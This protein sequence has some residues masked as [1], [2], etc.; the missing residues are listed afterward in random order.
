MGK[1]RND[2]HEKPELQDETELR[3]EKGLSRR[4]FFKKGA[5]AGVG[6]AAIAGVG[7]AAGQQ[8]AGEELDWD[9]EADVVVVGSG[10][11]GLPAAIRARDLGASVLV[12]EQNF[13]IGGSALHSGGRTSLGGGDALQQR[14]KEGADPEGMGLTQP[15]VPPE[16]LEDDPDLL[17]RDMTDWSVAN[18]GARFVYRYNERDLHR[19]WAD[20]TAA[21]RQFLMDNYVRFV[22]IDGTHPGGGV[23]RARAARTC[24][25]L[26]DT[27]DIRAGTIS[28]EDR[29]DP[30]EGRHT[31][32]NPMRTIPGNPGEGLGAP[33]W[34]WGG[35]ALARSLEF[36]AKE[37]GVRFMLNR[38]MDE[39]IREQQFSGRVLGVRTS[40]SPRHDPETGERLVSYGEFTGGEW[41]QGLIDEQRETVN[42]RARKAVIIASGGHNGNPQFRSM[43]HPAGRDPSQVPRAWTVAGPGR[44]NDASGIIAGMKVGAGLAGMQ[45][46]YHNNLGIRISPLL[47]VPADAPIY[48]GHPVFPFRGAYG[49]SVGA[50]GFE[51]LIAVNQ[52]G[53]RFFNEIR[54]PQN[55]S[56][57]TW[58]GGR[59]QGTR[60][61]HEHVQGDWRNCRHEWIRET[62]THDS[63]VEAA[64]A[65]NEGSQP[66]DYLPGPL[67]AIFDQA[68][69]DRA[70]WDISFPYTA[71]NGY[72]FSADTVEELA[73]KVTGNPNQRS[74]MRY[75][76]ETV[77]KWNASVE[78]GVDE[79]FEREQ[80]A[81]P[82]HRIETPPFYAATVVIEWHDSCG[83]LRINGRAQVEDLE[84]RVIPGLYAGGEASG[85]GEMHGLG[86]ATVHGYIAGTSAVAEERALAP[87]RAAIR[88][89]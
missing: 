29:G 85:G 32:F 82:M 49:L 70:G 41:G 58:P 46:T 62:F 3:D 83:G 74:R 59:A 63:G 44:A 71:D 84:G 51:H 17:F 20:N 60:E 81:E 6:A 5:A 43:F 24:I 64:L 1:K 76:K 61:W 30:D 34:V 33:G 79:D 50:P 54:L 52:V 9:Y 13:D 16:A 2:K 73:V 10:A 40:Y 65:M 18:D 87:S 8:T 4:D 66:P 68:A 35:F 25:K 21:T 53:R 55:F 89:S 47:G 57:P 39:I 38:R 28:P 23:S 69:I 56:S 72:F 11:S 75:L 45:Q 80:E 67:W 48:P 77:D 15:L 22:R 26:G 12:V 31:R 19:A 86:K 14:D 88:I 7:K 42:I 37:K 27:T 36:S 78:A